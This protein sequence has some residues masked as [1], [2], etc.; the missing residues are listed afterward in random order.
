MK[1]YSDEMYGFFPGGRRHHRHRENPYRTKRAEH[2]T[3]RSTG[4]CAL[5]GL[6]HLYQKLAL[7]EAIR[8][9]SGKAA[10]LGERCIDCGKCIR[11]CPHKAI[12]SLSDPLSEL[13]KFRYNIA[14]P[15]PACTV[16]REPGRRRP[17]FGG[18]T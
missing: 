17:A 14:L 15:E 3:F 18:L 9:R 10:I 4:L 2:E 7:A 12:K 16:I 5:H 1:R 13:H 8:V 11:V 6:H